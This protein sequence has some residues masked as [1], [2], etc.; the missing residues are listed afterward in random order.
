MVEAAAQA[1]VQVRF[2]P[3]DVAMCIGR[4]NAVAEF[5]PAVGI[6]MKGGA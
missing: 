1:E 4:K 2:L 6:W 3:S 5:S